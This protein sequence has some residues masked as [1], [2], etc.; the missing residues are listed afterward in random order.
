MDLNGILKGLRA[1]RDRT[2]R[3]IGALEEL[4]A[5]RRRHDAEAAQVPDINYCR[6]S[7]GT[8]PDDDESVS[9]S[10]CRLSACEPIDAA[11]REHVA[12]I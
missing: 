10:S 11:P 6:S 1:E 4:V 8:G 7:N 5:L 3:A 12:Q 9:E 2:E